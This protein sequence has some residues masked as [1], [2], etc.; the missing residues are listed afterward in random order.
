L[1]KIPLQADGTHKL[2]CK[3]H[4]HAGRQQHSE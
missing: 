4:R 2:L 1:A 3:C